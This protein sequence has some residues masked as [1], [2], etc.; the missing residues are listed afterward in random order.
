MREARVHLRQFGGHRIDLRHP[1]RRARLL[2]GGHRV[3]LVGGD[4]EA[5][6]HGLRRRD[7]R[8]AQGVSVGAWVSCWSAASNPVIAS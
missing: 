5:G 6:G 3:E 7:G 2:A 1:V 8:G 4:I